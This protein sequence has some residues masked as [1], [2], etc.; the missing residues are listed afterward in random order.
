M[1]S[2]FLLANQIKNFEIDAAA[3]FVFILDLTE[4]KH[5]VIS[6]VFRRVP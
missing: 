3:I 4:L 1:T 5:Y 2:L 6:N